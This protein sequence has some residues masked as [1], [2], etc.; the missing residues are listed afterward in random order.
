MDRDQAMSSNSKADG[1]TF[2]ALMCFLVI[3]LGTVDAWDSEDGRR[4][5]RDV[6]DQALKW[7][8]E[9]YGG[10]QYFTVPA[11]CRLPQRGERLEMQYAEAHDP[12]RGFRCTYRVMQTPGNAIATRTWS[13]SSDVYVSVFGGGQ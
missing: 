3:A 6:K 8:V 12:G 1:G 5:A 13:R 2:V 7:A 11:H 4:Q 10:P 9:Q